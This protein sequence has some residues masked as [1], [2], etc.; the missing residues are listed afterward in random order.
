MEVAG[1]TFPL[2]GRLLNEAQCFVERA[3]QLV[4]DDVVFH[5][6]R[7]VRLGDA[8]RQFQDKVA[9][10]HPFRDVD[11]LAQQGG[12]RVAHYAALRLR[13]RR[14]VAGG[15]QAMTAASVIPS[16]LASVCTKSTK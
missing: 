8:F 3:A 5:R 16:A 4:S 15:V 6:F 11:K 2:V 13:P 14:G 9:L 10:M 7:G 12:L 1:C